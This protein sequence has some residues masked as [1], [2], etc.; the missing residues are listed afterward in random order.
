MHKYQSKV[1]LSDVAKKAGVSLT[2]VSHV[3]NNIPHARIND[4]TRQKIQK[5]VSELGYQPSKLARS[6]ATGKT[7]I[8]GLAI[9]GFISPFFSTSFF[10]E[11]I[12]GIGSGLEELDKNLLL[13]HT[14]RGNFSD[15]LYRN[16]V[17]DNL[18]DGVI[19][20][21]N[22]IKDEFILRLDDEGFPYILV[23][24]ELIQRNVNCILSDYI[25]GSMKAVKHL[26]MLGHKDIA[27]IG[28]PK[29]KTMTNI[30]DRETGFVNAMKEK[31][32][33]HNPKLVVHSDD[34]TK[35]SGYKL[36]Q[37]LI[38]NNPRPTAVFAA[39]D[40][41][42][43]GALEAIKQNGLNIP[44]DI[45]VIGFDDLPEAMMVRPRL[46]TIRHA[47]FDIGNEAAKQLAQIINK[48]K[49]LVKKKILPSQLII[50]DSCG[51]GD[52]D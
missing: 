33:N 14:K 42:A 47:M 22:F 51:G 46:T 17:G 5:V 9:S 43:I 16:I 11:L 10:S 39:H 44:K 6:L 35:D 48:E 28:G 20:E 13:F 3:I 18:V 34:I 21:G 29:L 15:E 8:I 38:E 40:L 2:T 27:F 23:G 26:I 30:V 37:K 1:K 12:R 19:L 49:G 41:L 7:N 36:M 24:R 4:N 45:A 32:I 52:L 31:G 25:G 50:R